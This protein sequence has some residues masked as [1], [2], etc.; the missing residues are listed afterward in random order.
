LLLFA[1]IVWATGAVTFIRI[2]YPAC[3]P[4]GSNNL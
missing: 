2:F 3:L 1:A 4:P